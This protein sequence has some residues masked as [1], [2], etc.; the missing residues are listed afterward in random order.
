MDVSKLYSEDWKL[1]IV[2]IP[3]PIKIN[4]TIVMARRGKESSDESY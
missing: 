2:S 4:G 3:V 1:A